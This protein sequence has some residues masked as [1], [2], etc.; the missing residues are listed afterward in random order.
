M[1]LPRPLSARC[2]YVRTAPCLQPSWD[3]CGTAAAS[4]QH[5]EDR[6]SLAETP[7]VLELPD[8]LSEASAPQSLNSSFL[9][10]VPDG[11]PLALCTSPTS[12]PAIPTP[13]RHI[14]GL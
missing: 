10:Q 6:E 1:L 12:Q 5:Y 2:A 14:L 9:E 13:S 8:D 3:A 7:D 11:T 4:S